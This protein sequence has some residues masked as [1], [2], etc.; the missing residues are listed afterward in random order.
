MVYGEGVL[1]KGNNERE[2]S[3]HWS[4]LSNGYQK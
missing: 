2:D 1:R 4:S 3:V